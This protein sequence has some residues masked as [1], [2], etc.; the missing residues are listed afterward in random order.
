MQFLMT[1]KNGDMT[2]TVECPNLSD[3]NQLD[4]LF[5]SLTNK[6]VNEI[7]PTVKRGRGRPRKTPQVWSTK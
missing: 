7:K 6:A 1:I 2:I 3:I 5:N 4:K